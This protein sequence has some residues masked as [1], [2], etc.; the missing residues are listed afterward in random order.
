MPTSTAASVHENV[1]NAVYHSWPQMSKSRLDTICP[2]STPA[3]FKWAMEHS[4][5]IAVGD[6]LNVGSALHTLVLQPEQAE[7]DIAIMPADMN[8]RGKAN[9]L[10]Y[11]GW[12]DAN[13]DKACLKEST[14]QFVEVQ[15][16][17]ESVR[18]HPL[19]AGLLAR[20]GPVEVSITFELGGI[21]FRARLD[22]TIP[23]EGWIADVKT[24]GK[25][26]TRMAVENS[27]TD[28][29]YHRQ[30]AAYLAACRSAWPD[31]DWTEFYLIFVEKEPPYLCRVVN[32]PAYDIECGAAEIMRAIDIY[33]A[34]VETDEWP[35]YPIEV[36]EW[37]L[38]QW[39]RDELE[40]VLKRYS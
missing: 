1:P 2:P 21:D 26:A 25:A 33:R 8:Q 27:I 14:G 11:N 35:G 32:I 15:A 29:G 4:E 37:G 31:V 13:A 19:A 3:H 17:A 5:P 16:M 6:A 12:I 20:P 9:Q 34:C 30:A 28:R 39:K 36:T 38:R 40:P 10:A 24:I 22:K 18:A 23:S 7:Q